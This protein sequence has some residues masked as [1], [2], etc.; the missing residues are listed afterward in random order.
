MADE[1]EIAQLTTLA[2]R[3]CADKISIGQVAVIDDIRAA[4]H[5]AELH[6]AALAE[7]FRVDAFIAFKSEFI[8][9]I[10]LMPGV[11]PAEAGSLFESERDDPFH[12][13]QKE[14]FPCQF[15][16]R[17]RIKEL[18]HLFRNDTVCLRFAFSVLLQR[19]K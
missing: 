18:P 12:Q 5:G 1:S 4:A 11:A 13:R 17:R 2:E 15:L 6:Q 3:L 7:N 8:L 19:F 14:N 10:V 9:R 16:H